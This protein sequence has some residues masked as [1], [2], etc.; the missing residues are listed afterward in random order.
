MVARDGEHIKVRLC[1]KCRF[2]Y[3]YVPE[4]S[5]TDRL[6]GKIGSCH[7]DDRKLL[8]EVLDRILDLEQR[9]ADG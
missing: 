8:R 4:P 5:L 2:I 6:D 9:L 1:S 3:E 7:P